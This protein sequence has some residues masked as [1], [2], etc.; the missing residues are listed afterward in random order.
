M[1][2]ACRHA[3]IN[4]LSGALGQTAS[5]PIQ[6]SFVIAGTREIIS[7]ST[8][9]ACVERSPSSELVVASVKRDGRGQSLVPSTRDLTNLDRCVSGGLGSPLRLGDSLTQVASSVEVVCDQWAGV[10]SY[11][12]CSSGLPIQVENKHVLVMCNN[13]IFVPSGKSRSC[14]STA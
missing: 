9:T 7:V 5:E 1:D 2:E 8:D 10:R 12:I 13:K 4:G 11:Q 6:L 14:S 3:D